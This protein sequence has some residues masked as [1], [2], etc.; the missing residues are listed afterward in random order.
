M[1]I[2]DADV[3]PELRRMLNGMLDGFRL[4]GP[5]EALDWVAV[6]FENYQAAM[7]R[8]AHPAPWCNELVA[9]VRALVDK[10]KRRVMKDAP[11]S[12]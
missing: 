10:Y 12:Q 11:K 3:T 8:H 6:Y 5:I 1:K 9:D 4:V 7:E 2:K